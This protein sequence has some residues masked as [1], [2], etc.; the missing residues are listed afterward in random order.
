MY[1]VGQ[2][3]F[4]DT[5][6]PVIDSKAKSLRINPLLIHEWKVMQAFFSDYFFS[7]ASRFCRVGVQG[8]LCHICGV[9]T[10]ILGILS[11]VDI[12]PNLIH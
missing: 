8:P 12:H 2:Y 4:I 11:N 1:Y 10:R 7:V 6:T 9:Q 3:T 5:E